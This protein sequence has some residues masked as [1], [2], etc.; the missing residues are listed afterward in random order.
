MTDP[1]VLGA[2]TT[3]DLP[4]DRVLSEAIKADVQDAVVIGR[5][6]EGEL[7]FASAVGSNAETLL[8]LEEAKKHL[9]D[10]RFE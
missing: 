1:I 9:L 6:D 7:Y 2:E 8:L 10:L 3:L 5:D 4:S